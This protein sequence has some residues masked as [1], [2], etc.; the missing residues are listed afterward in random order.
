MCLIHFC[1]KV[2]QLFVNHVY[3]GGYNE[4]MWAHESGELRTLFE[5]HN[6]ID[7]DPHTIR[8]YHPEKIIFWTS[9]SCESSFSHNRLN[10]NEQ[11]VISIFMNISAFHHSPTSLRL[12]TSNSDVNT[13]FVLFQHVDM[14][15]EFHDQIIIQIFE[16]NAMTSPTNFSHKYSVFKYCTWMI[17]SPSAAS[18][19]PN[20]N[21]EISLISNELVISDTMTLL[22]FNC[23]NQMFSYSTPWRNSSCK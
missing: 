14:K 16:W 20:M 8:Y 4:I 11:N 19:L 18:T 23:A 3:F 22:F 5:D 7:Y 12:L 2:P 1:S 10:L 17:C 9:F 15:A 6:Y 13:K 21:Y